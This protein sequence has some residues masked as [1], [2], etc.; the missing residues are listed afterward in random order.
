MGIDFQLRPSS[1][2]PRLQL[3]AQPTPGWPF[4]TLSRFRSSSVSFAPASALQQEMHVTCR[5]VG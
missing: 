5:A 4:H 1:E 3:S 2:M